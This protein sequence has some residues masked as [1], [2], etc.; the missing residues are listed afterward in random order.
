MIKEHLIELGFLGSLSVYLSILAVFFIFEQR[1][2]LVLLG[3]LVACYAITSGIRL[4][5]FRE[6]PDKTKY[7]NWLEKIDAA[8]L[9]SLHSMRSIFLALMIGTFFQMTSVY[10]LMICLALLTGVSR[11][12]TKRHY[13]SDVLAGYVIGILLYYLAL[14]F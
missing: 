14:L 6:R 7:S 5:F 9:P 1:F 3:G 4:V 2:S 8:S 13:L 12:S 11:I 10:V